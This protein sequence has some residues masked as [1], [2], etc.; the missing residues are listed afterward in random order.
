MSAITPQ[1][2][3]LDLFTHG[4]KRLGIDPAYTVKASVDL[5]HMDS[6][7]YY[8]H[9]RVRAGKLEILI[10]QDG[11]ITIIGWTPGASD[12]DG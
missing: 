7:P 8:P 3:F 11:D 12:A 4:F 10:G 9:W 1:G 5:V 2:R 6:T